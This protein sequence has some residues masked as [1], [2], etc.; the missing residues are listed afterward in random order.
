MIRIRKHNFQKSGQFQQHFVASV[1]TN[2]ILL[3]KFKVESESTEKLKDVFNYSTYFMLCE[4]TSKSSL[5]I[6]KTK[7]NLIQSKN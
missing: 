4:K 1:F 7:V 5:R 3:N 2:L 6:L